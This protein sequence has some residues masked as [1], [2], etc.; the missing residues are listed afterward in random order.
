MP[1]FCHLEMEVK[2]YLSNNEQMFNEL[3]KNKPLKL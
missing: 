2:Y 1:E 3:K